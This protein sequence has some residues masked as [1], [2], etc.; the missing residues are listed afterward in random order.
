MLK[1]IG[2]FLLVFCLA[3]AFGQTEPMRIAEGKTLSELKA[4]QEKLKSQQDAAKKKLEAAKSQ[5]KAISAEIEALDQSVA[6]AQEQL[7]NVRA[8]LDATE[9][10]LAEAEKALEEATAAREKHYDTFVRRLKFLQESGKMGYLDVIMEAKD[11]NDLMSRMQYVNDIMEYDN[12]TLEML[13]NAENTIQVK[14]EQIAEE[15]ATIEILVA[16]QRE[17]TQ[18]LEDLRSEKQTAFNQFRADEQNYEKELAEMEKAGREVEQLIASATRP[19]T[20]SSGG[21][22]TR[23]G[24]FT[25]SGGKLEWPVPGRSYI[26]SGYGNRPR[27]IG[28][29]YEFHNGIDIPAS[30]AANIVAAEAGTVITSRYVNG[31]GYTV[32]IDHGGGLTTLYGHNSKLVVSVGEQVSRGQVIAKAGSTGNSTGNHCHFGVYINGAHTNPMSYLGG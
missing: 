25:Y 32:M 30:Y 3:F 13:R 7:D 5:Q 10:S 20:T 15:K 6:V 12:S 17:K 29:G 16:E 19:K 14:T 24:N 18:S 11:F 31:F 27:P 4:E 22:A 1:K 21:S 8:Q 26:S 23:S 9:A 2:V 28:S